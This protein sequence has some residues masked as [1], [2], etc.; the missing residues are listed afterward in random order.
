MIV[1]ADIYDEVLQRLEAIVSILPWGDPTDPTNVVGPII[2]AE[3]LDRMEGMVDRA[4]QA[5][6][7]V[8]C[9]GKRGDRA[10]RDSGTSRRFSPTS[11][12]T[13]RSP[14]TKSSVRCSA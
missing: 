13:P 4:K 8:L 12:R 9:G 2:R 1:H 10:A 14:R 11:T 7:R 5:A 6:A 3:Q